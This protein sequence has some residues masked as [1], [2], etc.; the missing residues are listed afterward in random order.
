[1]ALEKV[2]LLPGKSNKANFFLVGGKAAL[3]A[4]LTPCQVVFDN[5]ICPVTL[6]QRRYLR[7]HLA[8]LKVS[9]N[10]KENLC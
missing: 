1:M 3:H 2:G 4:T 6:S 8:L 10:M 7:R 9:K 5:V